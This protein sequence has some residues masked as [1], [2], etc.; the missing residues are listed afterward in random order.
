MRGQTVFSYA[1]VALSATVYAAPLNNG[2]APFGV[3]AKVGIV[4]PG[5]DFQQKRNEAAPAA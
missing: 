4:N 1:L 2:A 3:L 5:Q